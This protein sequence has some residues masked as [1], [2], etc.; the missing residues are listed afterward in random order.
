M[1]IVYNPTITGVSPNYGSCTAPT[2]VNLT[3]QYFTNQ[4]ITAA[5]GAD[6]SKV[7][8][9]TVNLMGSAAGLDLR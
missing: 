9:S 8:T 1:P 3:G 4:T 5:D 6:F 7:Y 2:S